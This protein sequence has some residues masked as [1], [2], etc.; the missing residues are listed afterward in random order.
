[1]VEYTYVHIRRVHAYRRGGFFSS[2]IEIIKF[3]RNKL[4]KKKRSNFSEFE[5]KLQTHNV[6]FKHEAKLFVL[7]IIRKINLSKCF[8]L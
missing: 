4:L 2:L 1:M 6:S 7:L 3:S 8:R 5:Y